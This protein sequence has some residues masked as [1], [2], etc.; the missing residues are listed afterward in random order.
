M[1]IEAYDLDSLRKIV[2]TLQKENEAL[3]SQL[4]KA[5]IA[6]ET[7]NPFEEKIESINEYDPDQG[8]R[9]LG[10]Y[11]T[12][13]LAKRFFAMFWGRED[14]YAKRGKNGGYFPQCDNRWNDA[15]CPKQHGEKMFCDDCEHTKWTK[16][17]LK[18][19]VSHLVGK[20]EDGTDVLG[21]YPL[22]QDGTCRFIVFDFDNHEKDA[23]RGC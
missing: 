20:N 11:I 12:E 6:F 14:V 3:R 22:L 9:I 15:L 18:K 8:E 13:D 4:I 17:D 19:I 7:P 10:R 23:P 21:F 16:L 5:N 1:N 2:R